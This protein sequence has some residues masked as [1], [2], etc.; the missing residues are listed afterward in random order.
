MRLFVGIDL[1]KENKDDLFRIKKLISGKVA[2]IN[3]VAKKNLHMTLRFIGE[4]DERDLGKIVQRL[5]EVKFDRFNLSFKGIGFYLYRQEPKVI[6]LDFSDGSNVMELQKKID[7]ELLDLFD[8]DQ[9]FTAHLTLGRIK[10]IKKKDQF[11]DKINHFE[12]SK[13]SFMVNSF[14]LIK[15]KLTKDGPKYEIIE[16][17]K[18]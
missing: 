6:R 18:P 14:S 1:P 11:F 13:E 17:F 15:S 5:N 4:V 3:W 8:A 16:T 9:K 10:L 7:E 12:F 2:K